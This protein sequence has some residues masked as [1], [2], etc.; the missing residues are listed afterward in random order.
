MLETPGLTEQ[1]VLLETNL[2]D[3]MTLVETL[4]VISQITDRVVEP[5]HLAKCVTA[6]DVLLL[7]GCP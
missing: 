7:A 6:G 2:W 3:S 1:T 5:D 4:G